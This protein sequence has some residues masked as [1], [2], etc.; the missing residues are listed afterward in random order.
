MAEKM[1]QPKTI[2]LDVRDLPPWERHPKIFEL[3]DG[4]QSG[5]ALILIND[6]DPRPLH[7]QLMMERA[8]QFEYSSKE[9]GPKEWVATIKRV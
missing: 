1:T 5:D 6:H 8:G 7:Y 2:T 3:L 4:F 9:K